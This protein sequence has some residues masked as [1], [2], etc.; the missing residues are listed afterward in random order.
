MALETGIGGGS[1]SLN[2]N[3]TELAFWTG[4]AAVSKA[5]DLLQN[6][7]T[8]LNKVNLKDFRLGLIIVSEDP[9]STTGIKIGAATAKG[10][11]R[12]FN[13][14][15]LKVNGGQKVLDSLPSDFKSPAGLILPVGKNRIFIRR[16]V[17]DSI[18]RKN[19]FTD[20]PVIISTE[21]FEKEYVA[22][23]FGINVVHREL[24]EQKISL[25]NAETIV[26]E[27]NIADRLIN[28]NASDNEES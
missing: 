14:P 27:P 6:I 1:V 22:E 18:S 7:R 24:Y 2:T 13:C 20:S 3:G 16:F 17:T 8:L 5:E 15:V 21:Q 26:L 12:A 9:G 25:Y 28:P 19:K 10:L 23:E 4:T 11:A